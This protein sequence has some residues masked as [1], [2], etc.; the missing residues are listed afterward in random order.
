[1]PREYPV[2]TIAEKGSVLPWEKRRRS[3]ARLLTPPR[4]AVRGYLL[5][6]GVGTDERERIKQ[7]IETL[8]AS[9][10]NAKVRH[11]FYESAGTSH[12]WQTW[13]R[14]LNDFARRL[15]Q[16]VS[17]NSRDRMAEMVHDI[18]GGHT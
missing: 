5:W 9:L 13:H 16:G 6:V 8:N 3:R 12:E 7:A 17:L 4:F 18:P 1:M 10:D 2:F 11:G 15:F 14:D